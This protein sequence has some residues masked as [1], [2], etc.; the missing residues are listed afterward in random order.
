MKKALVITL[1][2]LLLNTICAT[3]SAKDKCQF[4]QATLTLNDSTVVKGY[5][6]SNLHNVGAKVVVS[7]TCDGKKL[8]Y[9]I[10][11]ISSLDVVYSDGQNETYIPIYTWDKYSKKVSKK[12]VLATICFS[13]NH[14]VGYRIPSQYIKSSAA[15]PSSNFQS[16]SSKYNAWIFLYQVN[17]SDIVKGFWVHIPVKKAPKLKSIIK[18]AKKDF[19]EYPVVAE[20]IETRGLTAEEII[21]NPCILLEILDD[22][23]E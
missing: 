14:V 7:E 16:Y 3:I 5:L 6:R 10:A 11:D 21:R 4:P 20:T 2:M 19:K 17:N 13:G 15:V 1:A 18:N 23:L 9:E 12:P 22:S 8:S